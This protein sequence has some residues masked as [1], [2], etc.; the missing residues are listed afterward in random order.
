[1]IKGVN[2]MPS[3]HELVFVSQ[4]FFTF[5]IIMS[6]VFWYSL[7]DEYPLGW[8]SKHSRSFSDWISSFIAYA[9]L[10]FQFSLLNPRVSFAIWGIF[11][12]YL[13]LSFSLKGLHFLLPLLM[14]A[15][16]TE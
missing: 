9:H 3:R 2:E 12:P 1:M 8:N 14:T 11:T 13:Y 6:V 4:I 7:A 16:L 10:L 5:I 15:L